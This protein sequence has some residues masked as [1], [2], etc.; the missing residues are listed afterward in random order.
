MTRLALAAEARELDRITIEEI[1]VPGVALMEL[2]GQGAT[3]A[4]TARLDMENARIAIFCGAGNNGGDGYVIARHL[5]ALGHRPEVFLL[6]APARIQGDAAINLTALTRLAVPIHRLDPDA[7]D[8]TMFATLIKRIELT[9]WDACVDALLGTGLERPVTGRYADVIAI[10]NSQSSPI[11]AVDIPSGLSADT[12]Q[13]LGATVEATLTATFGCLKPGLVLYP[14]RGFV[15]ALEIISLAFAPSVHARVPLSGVALAP[16]DVISRLPSRSRDAHKGTCGRVLILA[17]APGKSGAAVL[18]GAGALDI[19][20]GLVTVGTHP[21]CLSQISMIRWALMSA[22]L[23]PKHNDHLTGHEHEALVESASRADVIAVGPGLG[24]ELAKAET[25]QTLIEHTRGP[26]VLDADALNIIAENLPLLRASKHPI[27]VT[28]HPGEMARLTG[29]PTEEVL[30][31]RLECA[32]LFAREHGVIVVLKSGSTVIAHP[33]GR[34]A[35]N[36]SGNP[37]MATAGM[38]DVLTGII[39]GL[40]AQGLDPWEAACVGV[41]LHGHAGDISARRCGEYAL[42]AE[43]LLDALPEATKAAGG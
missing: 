24:T 32:R 19:G 28:P 43:R 9:A 3:A 35:I 41:C 2:A 4:L 27:I 39:A 8:D 34:Y 40:L 17:G 23:L 20:A 38:G 1:G 11:L 12:G 16:A 18:A 6:A 5:R 36:T 37:G 42:T 22:P 26:M 33:D 15:G 21:S 7:L 13:P 30:R 31:N 14:G 29:S 10:L 25:L